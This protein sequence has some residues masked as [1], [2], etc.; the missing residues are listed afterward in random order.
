MCVRENHMED[1]AKRKVRWSERSFHVVDR[2]MQMLYL[3]VIP[4]PESVYRRSLPIRSLCFFASDIRD[5]IVIGERY[6]I[7]LL[8]VSWD[9]FTQKN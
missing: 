6:F 2:H 5:G 8:F 7:S 1:S 4:P 3:R 9:L